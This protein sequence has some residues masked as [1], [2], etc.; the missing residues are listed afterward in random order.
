MQK[1]PTRKYQV[2]EEAEIDLVLKCRDSH[3]FYE[4]YL[5]V[6][7]D[8]KKGLDSISKIWKRR[9]EFAK[10]RPQTFPQAETGKTNSREIQTLIAEQT[11]IMSD[12]AALTKE[13]LEVSRQILSALAHQNRILTGHHEE[14]PKDP[15]HPAPPPKPP[16]QKKAP[17]KQTPIMVGS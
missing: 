12:M 10:K 11:K 3:E 1:T 15:V 5:K 2:V 6:F 17:E 4:E 7:P 13:N 9:S 16:V 14:K 8:T